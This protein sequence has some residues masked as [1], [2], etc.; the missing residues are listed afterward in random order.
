MFFQRNKLNMTYLA[1]DIFEESDLE[2]AM[3]HRAESCMVLTNK[4]SANSLDEDYKN[5]L[6]A[7]S[8]KKFVYN[9]N[10]HFKDEQKYNIKLC[11]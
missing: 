7:L 1:G 9:M 6:T 5:I 11:I 3:L 4:N 10:K 2:R 8:L